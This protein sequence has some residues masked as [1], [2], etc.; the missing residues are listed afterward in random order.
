MLPHR[1]CPE[2]AQGAGPGPPPRQPRARKNRRAQG[3]LREGPLREGP[4]REYRS[5]RGPSQAGQRTWWTTASSRASQRSCG[6]S[7]ACRWTSMAPASS[8]VP[9]MTPTKASPRRRRRRQQPG[10]RP[11]LRG[12]VSWSCSAWWI[13]PTLGGA[14]RATGAGLHRHCRLRAPGFPE[15]FHEGSMKAFPPA[16]TGPRA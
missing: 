13:L 2:Q 16:A 9:R 15:R 12:G 6:S 4:L 8:Q 10:G 3:S 1:R 11:R 7:R 14:A 5:H